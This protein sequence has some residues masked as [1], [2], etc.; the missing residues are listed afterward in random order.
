MA[1]VVQRR[2]DRR[3]VGPPPRTLR[4]SA[5]LAVPLVFYALYATGLKALDSYRLHLQ[6]EQ[7]RQEIR[8]LRSENI[9]LQEAILVA[10]TDAAIEQIAREQ[11]GLVKPG[12]NALV[13]LPPPGQP[14]RAAAP[15][16]TT[17]R[18]PPPLQQWLSYFAG[19]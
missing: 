9:R 4:L 11:L 17:P 12:D 18:E 5:V 3:A 1:S 13:V 16:P 10:R 7:I 6:A 14:A 15:A 2:G 8:D 19:G